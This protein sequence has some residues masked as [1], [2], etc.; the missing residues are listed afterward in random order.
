MIGSYVAN[1]TDA[2]GILA[3]MHSKQGKKGGGYAVTVCDEPPTHAEEG[4]IS[5]A[6]NTHI[7]SG[8]E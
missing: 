5:L 3:P 8:R 7:G 1:F 2:E 6:W 4:N